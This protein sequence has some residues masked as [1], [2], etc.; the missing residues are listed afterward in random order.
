[1]IRVRGVP[2]DSWGGGVRV[3]F[4][5]KQTLNSTTKKTL[6]CKEKLHNHF[7]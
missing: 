2:F 5:K 4:R 1:M 6:A 7:F 3:F